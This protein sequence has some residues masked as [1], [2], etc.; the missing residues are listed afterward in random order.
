MHRTRS[1]DALF[2]RR[3]IADDQQFLGRVEVRQVLPN[4]AY[5]N[6][7][8]QTTDVDFHRNWFEPS[9][10]K[11][12]LSGLSSP[13]DGTTTNFDG[14]RLDFLGR[15]AGGIQ[16]QID[17]VGLPAD[18]VGIGDDHVAIPHEH[19]A[20]DHREDDVVTVSREDQM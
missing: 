12:S 17:L 20:V 1:V 15:F 6:R 13:T 4:D 16:I 7:A 18:F 2:C 8:D 14:L 3:I 5:R 19:L 10:Q 9:H 11:S